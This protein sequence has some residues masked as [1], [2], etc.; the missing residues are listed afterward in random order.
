MK[1]VKI[2]GGIGNQLFQYY[3][4]QY[5]NHKT[6]VSVIYLNALG[7]PEIPEKL[8]SF[9]DLDF[10]QNDY[11]NKLE[12]YPYYFNKFYR[13]NRKFLL[14]FPYFSNKIIVENHSYYL[15][16]NIVEYELYDGYWQNLEF[17]D[18]LRKEN[19]F[20][21]SFFNTDKFKKN[22]FYQLISTTPNGV[23]VHVR[24]GDYLSSDYHISL[25]MKYYKL[26]MEIILG[27]V[28]NPVFFLFSD[29]KLWLKENFSNSSNIILVLND[30][31]TDDDILEFYL[32]TLCKHYIIANS[33]FS[34]WPAYLNR[35]SDAIT[36]APK[37]WYNSNEDHANRILV[38]K[39]IL[40]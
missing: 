3:F 11:N 17:L 25:N 15:K 38:N 7:V 32:M 20:R 16:D 14:L 10:S 33:T 12:K 36:I 8:N 6:N 39:W 23:A 13:I 19:Q 34:W 26:S 40:H 18:Y 9:L 4:G 35:Q 22:V 30:S 37:H 27:K 28:S 5:L 1:L 31:D 29:D 2:W 24:R 21:F